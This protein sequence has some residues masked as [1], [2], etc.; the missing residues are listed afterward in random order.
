MKII[1]FSD[2]HDNIE[3][4]KKLHKHLKKENIKNLIFLGDLC[5]EETLKRIKNDYKHK[6]YL[7]KGNADLYK[8]YKIK[9]QEFID[10]NNV[11]I[12]FCHFPDKAKLIALNNDL[13]FVF[14]GHTHTPWLEK[15]KN[16]YLINPGNLNDQVF[17]TFALLNLNN[18]NIELKKL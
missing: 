18:K 1:I 6:L 15:I 8:D 11:K 12:A 13:D 9:E 4:W 16:T 3:N 17:S 7:V 14:Y 5:K 2:L 10:I